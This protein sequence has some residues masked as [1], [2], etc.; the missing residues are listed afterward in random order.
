MV[1][2][3]AHSSSVTPASNAALNAGQIHTL[4]NLPYDVL[5]SILLQSSIGPRELC[6]LERCSSALRKLV[7]NN[8]WRQAFL[9][10]R[11]CN[12]LRE[13]DSWK[14]EFARRDSWSRGWRQLGPGS[15]LHQTSSQL[16]LCG[17]ATAPQKL[18][19]FAMKMMSSQSPSPPSR[20]DTHIVDQNSSQAGIFHSVNAAL[21]CCK[22]YDV[23]VLRPGRYYER[24][25]LDKPVE[26]VGSH[27]VHPTV[28]IGVDGPTI[29][30]SGRIVGRI[31]N[32]RIE[33]HGRAG[34]A[35]SAAVLI[36]EGSTMVVEECDISSETGHCVAIQ[37][38][39]SYGYVMHNS[40]TN[41]KGVGVLVCV[42]GKGVIED[43]DICFNGLAGVAILS[44]AHPDVFSNKIHENMDSG[45]VITKKGRGRI[46]ENDIFANQRAGVAIMKEGAPIVMRNRI[47]AGRDS[48]VL[49]G[50]N[51][52]GYIFDN[53]IFA[54]KMAAV[55]IGREG[56]SLVTGNTIRDGNANGG[57]LCLS[58]HSKGLISAN[59]I[60]QGPHTSLQVPKERMPELA[61]NNIILSSPDAGDDEMD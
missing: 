51:G 29:E 12:A 26:I 17:Q 32:L 45:V 2:N 41:A 46:N 39:D 55:A 37:G 35:M 31:S 6:R 25:L 21:M 19:R 18:R 4:L 58:L 30:V 27:S 50:E 23:V 14:L 20:V 24:V 43:N 1:M 53:N 15:H 38:L 61:E 22:A 48:G 9:Q 49:V 5:I 59:V 16:R 44:E 57:S 33:Q 56:A 40:I 8:I 7:D 3:K 11:R 42:H 54:N 47:Y 60:Y 52:K 28:I 34:G 13:P 36:K 10:Q